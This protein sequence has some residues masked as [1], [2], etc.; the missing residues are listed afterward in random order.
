MFV[1]NIVFDHIYRYELDNQS[2]KYITK[3]RR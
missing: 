2:L 3:Y 1:L